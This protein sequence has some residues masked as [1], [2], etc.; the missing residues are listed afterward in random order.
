[1][2]FLGL[3]KIDEERLQY[4]VISD[5]ARLKLTRLI[6]IASN[7]DDTSLHLLRQNRFVNIANNVLG[8]PLYILESDDM[9][10]YQVAEHAWHFGEIEII[11][12]RPNTTQLVGILADMLQEN[13]LDINIVNE[14]L[15]EDGTSIFF[16]AENYNNVKVYITPVEEI[17]DVNDSEEHPNIRKLVKRM[18]N[19]LADRDYSAVLHTSATIFETL[20][21]DV[22]GLAAIENQTLGGFFD[23]YRKNSSLPEPILDYIIEIYRKRN[24][25]PLAGHGSTQLPNIEAEEAIMLA[26]MTKTF[27]RIE[28][29]LALPH[30]N[31]IT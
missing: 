28:R 6:K 7:S 10:E 30:K 22:V 18:D 29:K 31:N 8:K 23:R 20:A 11:M 16:E 5:K 17:E 3:T 1:M 25:E 14:I 26:E 9:G 4:E 13:L 19:V 15:I 2:G 27:V 21:K 24:K 12:R